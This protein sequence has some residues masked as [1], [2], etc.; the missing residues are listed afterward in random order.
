MYSTS[1]IKMPPAPSRASTVHADLYL[2]GATLPKRILLAEIQY[3]QQQLLL[4]QNDLSDCDDR[5]MLRK[6]PDAFFFPR[7]RPRPRPCIL[8]PLTLMSMI[9]CCCCCWRLAWAAAMHPSASPS[10]G[11][12][13]QQA[14]AGDDERRREA[15][16]EVGE[17]GERVAVVL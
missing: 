13:E 2:Y 9:C 7:P 10:V 5:S 8:D 3:K 14:D 15:E 12:D 11:S 4:E 1:Q 17:E 16:L 6:N